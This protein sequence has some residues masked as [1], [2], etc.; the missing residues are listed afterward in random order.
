MGD[1]AAAAGGAQVVEEAVIYV[2]DA[3]A[4]IAFLDKEEGW[5]KVDGLLER[6]EQREIEL[7]IN[8]INLWEVY[9]D[10]LK[11]N[12]ALGETFLSQFQDMAIR[13]IPYNQ[14]EIFYASGKLK[15]AYNKMAIADAIGL[16]TASHFHGT[17]VTSDHSELDKYEPLLDIPFFWIRPAKTKGAR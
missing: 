3:C 5:E 15:A 10:R 6:A 2:L 8:V 9:Y 14:D 7:Y 4:L 11:R 17:F 12:S 1:R 16:A 13:V